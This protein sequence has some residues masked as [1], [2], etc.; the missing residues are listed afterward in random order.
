MV[1]LRFKDVGKLP[2]PVLQ[3]TTVTFGYSP[4]KILYHDVDFGVDLVRA[5][6]REATLYCATSNGVANTVGPLH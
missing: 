1:R 3:F 6:E 5:R 4:D 2:P